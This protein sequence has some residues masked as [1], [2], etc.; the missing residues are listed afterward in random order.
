MLIF[1]FN[2]YKLLI[3]TILWYTFG[4]LFFHVMLCRH[5]VVMWR[6][7]RKLKRRLPYSLIES[8][9]TLTG[10]IRLASGCSLFLLVMITVLANGHSLSYFIVLFSVLHILLAISFSC[11]DGNLVFTPKNSSRKTDGGIYNP[12]VHHDKQKPKNTLQFS[13]NVH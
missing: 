11:D 13:Y 9:S 8:R 1:I 4:L 3:L 6:L 12:W 2:Q 5:S 10:K 7:K